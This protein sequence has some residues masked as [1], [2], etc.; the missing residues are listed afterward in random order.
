MGIAINIA[1]VLGPLL[2]WIGM[3]RWLESRDWRLPRWSYLF[4][5]AWAL[6]CGWVIYSCMIGNCS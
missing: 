2:L 1:M 4:P 5:G 6:I 3:D